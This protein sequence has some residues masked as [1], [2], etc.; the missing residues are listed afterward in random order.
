MF[1]GC[2]VMKPGIVKLYKQVC[3][4]PDILEDRADFVANEASLARAPRI[5]VTYIDEVPV[6]VGPDSVG[7]VGWHM[8]GSVAMAETRSDSMPQASLI[9]AIN[10]NYGVVHWDFLV[11]SLDGKEFRTVATVGHDTPPRTPG[12]LNRLLGS[13]NL[14]CGARFVRVVAHNIGTIPAWH[15]SAGVPAW[16]FVDEILVNAPKAAVSGK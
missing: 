3:N 1:D 4:D 6:M 2:S 10:E 13:D 12:P 5:N 16:L 9:L 14:D 8:E 7:K 15:H 11:R